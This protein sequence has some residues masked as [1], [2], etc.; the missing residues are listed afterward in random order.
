MDLTQ[1]KQEMK[2]SADEKVGSIESLL[3]W[4]DLTY[5]VPKTNSLVSVRNIKEYFA[6]QQAYSSG[7][8]TDIVFNLQSGS[9]YINCMNSALEFELTVT[10]SAATWNF[11]IGSA[12]NLFREVNVSTRSGT[13]VDRFQE[14]NLYRIHADNLLHEPEWFDQAGKLMGYKGNVTTLN[15]VTATPYKFIIPLYKLAP[16]FSTEKL[17]PSHLATGMRIEIQL[18]RAVNALVTSVADAGVSF[19]IKDP[20]LL[21]DSHQLVDKASRSLQNTSAKNGLEY[22][23]PA[24]YTETDTTSSNKINMEINKSVG[25]ALKVFAVSRET[26]AINVSN[27]D[28]FA[29]EVFSKGEDGEIKRAQYR[30]GSQY[31]PHREIVGYEEAYFHALYSVGKYGHGASTTT[32]SDFEDGGLGSIHA[33][34]ES[35][36]LLKWS[37]SSINNSRSLTFTGEWNGIVADRQVDVFLTYLTV[38]RS[39]LNNTIVKS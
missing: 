36:N 14:C 21:I 16:I 29:S 12:F 23:Y 27:F 34:L 13:E 25:R 39:Y 7:T 30:L 3:G 6:Q 20:K 17:M 37:G 5:N 31:F 26:T 22:S 38:S 15:R 33:T 1:V 24:V 8:G 35:H 28:S 2:G 32:L 11:G 4:N 19:T 10:T 18:D 9:Q